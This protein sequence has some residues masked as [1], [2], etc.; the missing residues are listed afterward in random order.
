MSYLDPKEAFAHLQKRVLEGIEAQF[1]DGKIAGKT[2]S[3]HLV[4]L[5]VRD[6]LHPDDLRGQHKAKVSGESW[7]V[8][9][10]ANLELRDNAS[11]KLID[12]R[13]IRV[14]DL[15][16]TTSRYSYI[17]DGQ[18]YQVDNQW[19]LKP[20]VYT[21]RRDNG[22]LETSFNPQNKRRFDLLLDPA[23]KVFS[24]EYNKSGLPLYP[25]LKTM[26]VTDDELAKSW[27]KDILDINRK[28]RGVEGTL[29]K[30]YKSDKR[31]Q[32]PSK[33]VAA[34]HFFSAMTG[35]RLRPDAT[36]ITLGKPF[37]NV[38]GEALHLASQ[39]MLDV[40]AGQLEDDRDNL[41]FKDLRTTGDFAFDMLKAAKRTV[42][43]KALRKVNTATDVR[44]VLRLDS[45]SKPIRDVFHKNMAARVATQINPVEMLGSSFQTTVM[46]QGGIKS[47]RSISDETKFVNPSHLGF[48]DPIISPEGSK[49]GV[50][51][52]LPIGIRK[53]GKEAKI[54]LYNLKTGKTEAVTPLQ[55]VHATVVLPDQ[56]R[57]ENNKPVPIG[58]TVKLSS[59]DNKIVDGSFSDAQ[60]VLPYSSQLFSMTTNLI[61][62][63]GSTSGGRASMAGRHIEQAISLVHREQPLVQAATGVHTAGT[64]TFEKL[65]GRQAS[66][67]APVDGTV[68]KVTGDAIHL[69]GPDGK[70]HEVQTYHN[71]PLN[72]SKSMLHSTP[73]VKVGDK[74]KAQQVIADT[75]YAKNG[76]LALGSNLR[77]GFLPFQGLNFEDGVVISESA[78]KKLSSE[79]LHKPSLPIDPDTVLSKTRYE[80]SLGGT[81]TKEQLAN[82]GEEGVVQV[83]ARVKHGDPLVLAMKPFQ[84]KDRTGLG[85]IRR[86]MSGAHT[87]RALRWDSDFE[88]EVVGVHRGK[89]GLS[90]HVKTVEPMQ[91][92]DKISGRSGNKGVVSRILPDVEMPHTKDGR[93]IEVALNPSGVP[94]RLNVGQVFETLAAKIAEKTGKPYVVQNFSPEVDNIATLTADLKK[95]GIPETEELYDPVTKQNLGH[96]TVGTMHMLKLVHQADKK[97]SARSGM[98]IQGTPLEKYD[99]NLQPTSGAGT[100][101]QSMG[102]LGLY[103]LLAH[104]STANIREMQSY[105]SQGEDP[106]TN[107]AKQWASDHNKIW[108]AI[109][110]GTPLP[111]PKS[112]F[113]FQKFHDYLTAAGVNMEKKG[114]SFMLSPLTDAQIRNIA[115]KELPNPAD[116]L[117]AKKNKNG[118]PTPKPGGLFDET[119]TGGH[120]GKQWTRI[121]LAEPIP[122]PLFE[123]PIASLTGLA[124]KDML[125]V[126]YGEKAISSGGQLTEPSSGITGGAGIALLLNKVNVTAALPLAEKSLKEAR[127]AD[128]DKYLKRVKYLRALQQTGMSPSEAYL[129]HNLPV[130]P[131]VMRPVSMLPDG[132]MKFDGLNQLYSNF[133]KINDKLKDP[134]LRANL[135]D[136]GKTNLR[137]DYYDGVRALMGVGVPYADAKYKGLLHNIS[138]KEPKSGLFQD[139]LINRRQD[140]TMRSV[141]VPEPALGLD[142]VGLPEHAA[143]NLFR[144]FVIRKLKDTGIIRN[145]LQGPDLVKKKTPEVWKA[146]DKVMQERPVL[147]KRDPA[148]HKYNV[149]AFKSKR[150]P[151]N[152]IQIHPLVVG[153]FGADFDGDQMSA[154]VPI[155]REAIDEAHK[156]FPSK[157]IFS[158]A[159][160]RVMYQPTLE[161]ALGLYKLSL[162][163]DGSKKFKSPT[164]VL[165]AAQR[166]EVHINDTVHL[167]EGPTTAGRLL[168][169]SA[170]PAPMQ[171]EMIS[172]LETRINKK[173]LDT[174]LTTIGKDH[175]DAFG[176]AVNKLKDLGNGT[177]FGAVM[178]PRPTSVGHGF[179]FQVVGG[180]PVATHAANKSLFI[181]TGTHTLSL[182]DFAPD[183]AVR[184]PL[185]AQARKEAGVVYAN[186]QFTAADKDRRAIAIY[187]KA[188]AAI[189][190]AHIVKQKKDPSNLFVMHEAGVKPGWDQYKQMVLAPMIYKDSSDREIA[191]PVTK[192]YSEGL[193]VGSYWT[194][195]HGAR[196]GAVMK[197]Q[198][199]QEPGYMSK[200][201]MNNMMHILATSPDC[202]TTK[203]IALDINEPD[204]HDRHLVSEFR[205]GS[206]HIPAGTL[207]TPA[208][209]GQIKQA[210]KDAQVLVRSPL[211]CEEEKGVCQKCVGLSSTGSYHPLGTNLGVMAAHAV[212][213]RAVQL[214]LRSFHT[215]GIQ[216]AGGGSKLLNSFTRFKQLMNLTEKIPN[217]ASLAMASGKIE[218][219]E[220][221]PTGTDIF[222]AGR[223]KP[224]H[225][226]KD[227]YGMP[228]DRPLP[229][230]QAAGGWTPPKVGMHVEAGSLLSDPA[231]TFIN[232]RHLYAATG[233]MEKVQNHLT[234]EIHELY[235]GEGIKRRAV[236][237]VVRAMGNLTEILDPGDHDGVLRGEYRPLLSVNKMNAELQKEGRRP[238]DHKPVLKGVEVMPR[239]LQEDWMAKLQHDHLKET[240]M[241][242]AAVGAVSHTHSVHPVPGIAYGAEFGLTKKDSTT[243]GRSHLKDV[244]D[245]HY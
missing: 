200:L 236:E 32:A 27:G 44:D 6:T 62:F 241:D 196:R 215:G 88:G 213:E 191:T 143:L 70:N 11:G 15:P 8:P 171:K 106:Q 144:P 131:P 242:A 120:G 230:A 174:L 158:E 222:L 149:Q 127:G 10:Y 207:L 239:E 206:L 232:P 151:G 123:T 58:S 208:V 55:F 135:T 226:G 59:K 244:S 26:G 76:V 118:D 139:V 184:D 99:Q 111:P 178:I 7:S 146:L 179:D 65:L 102:T 185:V 153:G 67:A 25:L 39:R 137:K 156:M 186:K 73:L 132:N 235:R 202:G 204:V 81:F 13:K 152:A 23:T 201:L 34:E 125:S 113:V 54:P 119:L 193:D 29:E 5:E 136:A 159:T 86:N 31:V 211:K 98:N 228:L 197:V 169:A 212:G 176:D 216:E 157:N 142:E 68:T 46:G 195:M 223:K 190:A 189:G 1:P 47:E 42:D 217:E 28:A 19:Q 167:P 101:G 30:F 161:S 126:L 24:M 90:V 163:K 168:L 110:T 181:P 234:N 115:R 78:A 63:L 64:E 35:S 21:R 94:G 231:R 22:E 79:H 214:T 198:E 165:S 141:V 130:L 112:T 224:H 129:L 107:P 4:G 243:L 17:V 40:H 53:E 89:D 229:H 210:K 85:A 219:M 93:H 220:A 41:V 225:V 56:V 91:V 203:G 183:Y 100:G 66:H 173:G 20:G 84:L 180:T 77:V 51:L 72:D 37:E 122:N 205:Q 82:V 83:G 175:H 43:E 38:T 60:Y 177:T 154:F 164:E 237:T 162:V 128:V 145:E 16:K 150:V 33:E 238:I 2:Q 18:E 14:A 209:V 36:A 227:T 199:V 182:K 50:N 49:T 172:N 75:N 133:A 188:D 69:Q 140:L 105:K 147:L 240:L 170:L 166:G 95:H 116:L 103:A 48:L 124:K 9:I 245:F 109:Q 71:Y 187:K 97:L 74:V 233:S 192:S 12:A 160:G 87:D 218:K 61:P 117:V 114:H 45:F 3:L 148:L 92:A 221:T 52:R 104:G 138:G 134:T 80:R 194:Q 121:G 96:T 57:W 155:T 108:A